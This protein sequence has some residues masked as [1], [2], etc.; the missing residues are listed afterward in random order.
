MTCF[1]LCDGGSK[2]LEYSKP[3]V[4]KGGSA[5]SEFAYDFSPEIVRLRTYH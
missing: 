1:V 3:N 2:R 5:E 4:R